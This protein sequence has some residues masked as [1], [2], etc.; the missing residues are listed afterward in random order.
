MQHSD[1]CMTRR[2]LRVLGHHYRLCQSCSMCLLCRKRDYRFGMDETL[3]SRSAPW[4]VLMKLVKT[5][6]SVLEQASE[7]ALAAAS[8]PCLDVE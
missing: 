6:G 1:K 5:S 8:V 4:S 7:Q 2:C 3:D